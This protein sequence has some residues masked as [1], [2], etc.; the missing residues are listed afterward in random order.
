[1]A[2]QSD[3]SDFGAGEDSDADVYQCEICGRDFG[4]K[5]G[6]TSHM[7]SQHTERKIKAE[8]LSEIDRV[9]RELSKT[10]TA[11]DMTQKGKYS[12]STYIRIFDSWNEA[13]RQA[14][15]GINKRGEVPESELLSQLISLADQLEHSPTVE[16]IRKHSEFGVTT[17]TNKFGSWNEAL[18]RAGLERNIQRNITKS[19]LTEQLIQ[20]ADT[21]GRTPTKPEMNKKGPYSATTYQQKFDSWNEAI[22]QAGL[23]TNIEHNIS[24]DKLIKE[25]KRLADELGYTPTRRD[26]DQHGKFS[27]GSYRRAFSSWNQALNRAGYEINKIEK[28]PKSELL[29]EINRLADE[30]GSAPTS[31]QMDEHGA[32]GSNDY[33]RRFGSWTN[34]IREAGLDIDITSR[35]NISKID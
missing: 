24:N 16:D 2:E 30:V 35:K 33:W 5:R 1:M 4:S 13:L 17:Y 3:F 27:S 25:I 12:S 31:K 26:M 18:E 22:E 29:D 14:N 8:L 23:Q 32:Y 19:E 6:R 9:K 11:E 10:P 28:I 34:A 21:L 20:F 15:A 7:S